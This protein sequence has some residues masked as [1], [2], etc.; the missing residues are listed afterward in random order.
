MGCLGGIFGNSWAALGRSGPEE[1]RTKKH[2][3]PI[4]FFLKKNNNIRICLLEL[5][6]GAS[7]GRRGPLG[8]HLKPS[9][10]GLGLCWGLVECSWTLLEPSWTPLR[11]ILGRLGASWAVLSDRGGLRQAAGGLR[12][13]RGDLVYSCGPW[14]SSAPGAPGPGFRS[15]RDTSGSRVNFGRLSRQYWTVQVWG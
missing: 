4:F 6:G 9:W 10:N 11:S 5:S 15:M 8:S 14:W 12:G 7:R 2:S 1:V 3:K 13:G